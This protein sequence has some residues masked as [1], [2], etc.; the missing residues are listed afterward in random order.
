MNEDS[1]NGK[2][3][4]TKLETQINLDGSLDQASAL[5][6]FKFILVNGTAIWRLMLL[7]CC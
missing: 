1:D 7:V 4:E 5:V 3:G 2:V 6:S